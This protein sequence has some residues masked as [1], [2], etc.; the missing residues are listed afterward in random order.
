[1]KEGLSTRIYFAISSK[2]TYEVYDYGVWENVAKTLQVIPS[3]KNDISSISVNK[4]ARGY[5]VYFYITKPLSYIDIYNIT[6]NVI[7]NL[8]DYQ[9]FISFEK[10]FKV[11]E[12]TPLPEKKDD[13]NWRFKTEQELKDE[14]G[15][16]WMD[17]IT[18]SE[19]MNFLL[20][21]KIRENELSRDFIDE[22]QNTWSGYTNIYRAFGL[23]ASGSD[24]EKEYYT[25]PSK[26]V[27]NKPLKSEGVPPKE[28]PTPP[29]PEK[30]DDWNWRFKT[31]EELKAEL[32]DD[33]HKIKDGNVFAYAMEYLLGQQIKETI[34][35]VDA[36]F[37]INRNTY[38]G[39]VVNP[40]K[41]FGIVNPENDLDWHISSWMIT[42][43]PQKISE[44]DVQ[45][46][47]LRWSEEKVKEKNDINTIKYQ[48][49]HLIG[50]ILL[51]QSDARMSDFTQLIAY[52]KQSEMLSKELAKL[53]Q[54]GI[55]IDSFV[56]KLIIDKVLKNID[57]VKAQIMLFVKYESDIDQEL[58]RIVM[59]IPYLAEL[60][61]FDK[62]YIIHIK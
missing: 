49:S 4:I 46:E 51:N 18:W 28:E 55:A 48:L 52:A 6:A 31:E 14:Y 41:V 20:G 58:G 13:W 30:E 1:M 47:I 34:D 16:D 42:N 10:L 37:R 36:I 23:S 50:Y 54:E 25:I 7:Q 8:I 17:T 21:E 15:D 39:V 57:N 53:E 19:N 9:S 24:P 33:I 22:I 40:K 32:G 29:L 27:T 56:S 60:D 38:G 61:T 45:N 12:K 62:D 11:E 44:K 26:A 35:S 43:K 5:D 3:L 2:A 59:H